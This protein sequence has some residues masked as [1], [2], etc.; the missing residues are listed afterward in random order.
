MGYSM[1][2]GHYVVLCRHSDD[3]LNSSLN[4]NGNPWVFYNDEEIVPYTWEDVQRDIYDYGYCPTYVV[5]HKEISPQSS[6]TVLPIYSEKAIP[7]ALYPKDVLSQ[8]VLVIWI[9]ILGRRAK[10]SVKLK[11]EAYSL[12]GDCF[13]SNSRRKTKIVFSACLFETGMCV[14]DVFR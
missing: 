12:F 1:D 13:K 5:Y 6:G 3:A 9:I 11:S 4:N 2:S 10:F 7:L 8:V 14:D